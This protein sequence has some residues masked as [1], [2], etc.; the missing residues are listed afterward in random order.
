M[1]SSVAIVGVAAATALVH[2]YAAPEPRAAAGAVEADFEGPGGQGL[3]SVGG[4]SWSLTGSWST[5]QGEA[6]LVEG[7]PGGPALA[8]VDLE[9]AAV[10]VAVT[11][12][13]SVDGAG[14][15]FGLSGPDDWWAVLAQPS[16]GGYRVVRSTAVGGIEPVATIPL[17]PTAPGTEVAVAVYDGQGYVLVDRTPR[18]MVPQLEGVG[19]SAGL[20]GLAGSAGAT[21]RSLL[22]LPVELATDGLLGGDLLAS[23]GAS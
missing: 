13:E 4:R 15:V 12:G 6:R 17:A 22:A 2:R 3:A 20:I 18:A 8:T 14:L 11:L 1:V 9:R 16:L 5:E 7:A 10:A 19:T 23:E 21:W